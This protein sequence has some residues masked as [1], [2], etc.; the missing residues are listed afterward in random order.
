M[1]NQS[2]KITAANIR[3]REALPAEDDKLPN[4]IIV[5]DSTDYFWICT[6]GK[7]HSFKAN[8]RKRINGMK[9]AVCHGKQVT[10]DTCLEY[11]RPDLVS[12]WHE[13]NELKP[14]DVTLKSEIEILWKCPNPY[15][16]PYKMPVCQRVK[17]KYGCKIC[18]GKKRTHDSFSMELKVK[19]P[20]IKI[21][22]MYIRYDK[23]IKSRCS[24]CGR[25]WEIDA[26]NLLKRGCS[27]C[28]NKKH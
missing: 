11:F 1:Q 17:A 26:N 15:H 27:K 6:N 20:N 16:E 4:E 19:F 22:S 25:V 18:S 13:S 10:W 5:S 28:K 3:E 8:I 24:I 21:L 7:S 23:R 2:T 12:E 14:S 9:C